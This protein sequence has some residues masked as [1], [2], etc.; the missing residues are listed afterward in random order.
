M[1][2][3]KAQLKATRNFLAAIVAV[4]EHLTD[5]AGNE[6]LTM[7]QT[8]RKYRVTYVKAV[9]YSKGATLDNGDQLATA[10]RGLTPADACALADAVLEVPA[11][12]H[13]ERY[14]SL[15]VGQKRMNSGNRVRAAIK[16]GTVT[17]EQVLE[18]LG[19]KAEVAA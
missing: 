4:A 18:L 1:K 19:Q 17:I 13:A 12:T 11:G 7:S 8:L 15:N 6:R 10:L 3:T 16:K 2:P 14:A 9:S 5:A